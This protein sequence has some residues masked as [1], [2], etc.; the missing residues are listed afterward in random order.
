ME[1]QAL[2][3]HDYLVST[4]EA[5]RNS[6]ANRIGIFIA[7]SD[8]LL[9]H[10]FLDYLSAFQVCYGHTNWFICEPCTSLQNHRHF[11]DGLWQRCLIWRLL[12]LRELTFLVQV[13][14]IFARR[15]MSL[16]SGNASSKDEKNGINRSRGIDL[17]K[18]VAITGNMGMWKVGY[19]WETR[20]SILVLS[21][22]SSWNCVACPVGELRKIKSI[23]MDH[24]IVFVD[25]FPLF[26]LLAVQTP[27]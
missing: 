12:V 20:I 11:V 13:A 22:M 15:E 18:C 1:S 2:F 3:V 9:T 17:K 25:L 27:W 16:F 14:G 6:A 10:S 5:S 21:R 8:S 26:F 7:Y 24:Y 23:E 4:N 19:W